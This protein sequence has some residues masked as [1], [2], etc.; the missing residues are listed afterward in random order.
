MVA[1]AA[2]GQKRNSNSRPVEP[3]NDDKE[4]KEKEKGRCSE[5]EEGETAAAAETGEEKRV[6]DR[7]RASRPDDLGRP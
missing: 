6:R 7:R 2:S 1:A 5:W 3:K 4:Q